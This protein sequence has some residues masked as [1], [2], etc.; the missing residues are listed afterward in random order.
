MAVESTEIALGTPAPD[1]R[2]TSVD[3]Q[4]VRL[5][6]LEGEALLVVFVCNHCPYVRHI[7]GALGRLVNDF[8]S[9]DLAAV[10]ICSNDPAEYPDDQPAGLRAQRD[11]AGWAFPYLV[12]ESQKTARD[13]GATCTPDLFLFDANQKLAY[14]GA[15]DASTPKNGEPIT[16]EL[17]RAAVDSVLR[18]QPVPQPQRP[19]R[20]CSIKWR[21][22]NEPA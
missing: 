15:F 13:Y 8:A 6:D 1:F 2:L 21:A 7:E 4:A 3:G 19:A 11:R 12:D 9:R 18:G 5:A 14:H 22:G 20:G 16:G 17:L 10:A